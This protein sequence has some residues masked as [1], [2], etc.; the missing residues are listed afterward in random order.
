MNK[1]KEYLQKKKGFW[2]ALLLV[3]LV[4]L[5]CLVVALRAGKLQN[6]FNPDSFAQREEQDEEFDPEGYGLQEDGRDQGEDD[7]TEENSFEQGENQEKKIQNL[8]LNEQSGEQQTDR[9]EEGNEQRILYVDQKVGEGMERQTKTG[10]NENAGTPEKTGED[11]RKETPGGQQEESDQPDHAAPQPGG[12]EP[13]N[14]PGDSGEEGGS[15]SSSDGDGEN[16]GSSHPDGGEEGGAWVAE[17]LTVTYYRNQDAVSLYKEQVPSES[18]VRGNI[19]VTS[20]WVEKGNPSNKKTEEETDFTLEAIPE[21]YAHRLTDADVN[22]SFSLTVTCQGLTGTVTCVIKNDYIRYTGMHVSYNSSP[23]YVTGETLFQGQEINDASI[24]NAIT[25]DVYGRTVQG[26]QEVYLPDEKNYQ[27]E[28]PEETGGVA[29]KKEDGSQWTADI[30]YCGPG[31]GSSV[32]LRGTD[33]VRYSVRDYRL[34]VMYDENTVLDTIYTD[35]KTVVLNGTYDGRCPYNEMV[36]RLQKNGK[37]MTNADGYLTDLFYGWSSRYPAVVDNREISYTF[38]EGQHTQIMYA[39]PLAPLLSEGYLVKT[40]GDDQVLTGYVPDKK[41]ERLDVPYGITRVDLGEDFQ[42][43]EEAGG[44]KVLALSATVN[45]VNLSAAGKKFPMLKEYSLFPLGQSSVDNSEKN[46]IFS[47]EDGLLYSRDQS[48]LWKVPADCQSFDIEETVETIAEGALS[49]AAEGTKDNETLEITMHGQNPP[50][51]VRSETA[52]VFGGSGCQVQVEVPETE[53]GVVKDLIYKR[54]LSSWGAVFDEELGAAGAASACISTKDHASDRYENNGGDVYAVSGGSRSLAF[55]TRDSG[56]IYNVPEDVEGIEPY[57]FAEP[58]EVQFVNVGENIGRLESCSFAT[59]EGESL[60]GVQISGDEPIEIDRYVAGEQAPRGI[61]FYISLAQN[62]TSGWVRR[63]TEDYGAE[64]A[65]SMLT[66]AEGSLFIDGQGCAYL[67]QDDHA[68]T[69]CSVPEDLEEYEIPSGYTLNNVADGAFAWCQNLIYL[70]LPDVTRVG[71]HAF[72]NCTGLEILVLSHPDLEEIPEAFAGCDALETVV[73]GNEDLTPELP[74][75]TE[76]LAGSRYF[77]RDRMVCETKDDGGCAV[78]NVP[79]DTAG[80]VSLPEN[81]TEIGRKAF[82]GCKT[83][84]GIAAAQMNQ[85]RKIGAYAFSGCTGLEEVLIGKACTSLGEKAFF[86]CDALKTVTWLGDTSVVGDGVFAEN[87]RLEAVYFGDNSGQSIATIGAYTFENCRSLQMV[88]FQ[89]GVRKIGDSCFRG[90]S[91]M[92]T[93]ITREYAAFCE[94]IGAYAF[95]DCSRYSQTLSF[96]SG[97]QEIGRGAFMNC[98]YLSSMWIPS[99]LREIPEDCFAGCRSM[100][101]V[102]FMAGA[103]LRSVGSHAFSG[104]V[105]LETLT[106]L[107]LLT[108]LTSLGEGVFSSEEVDG[109]TYAACT[110]LTC[111]DLPS[112]IQQI[113]RRAFA[114]CT[115]LEELEV[116]RAEALTSLGSGAFTGCTSLKSAVLSG[117]GIQVLPENA[118]DGCRSLEALLLPES[119]VSIEARAVADCDSLSDM[120]IC[121]RDKVVSVDASALVGTK[122]N[123]RLAIYVPYTENHGLRNAYRLSLGWWTALLN[124]FTGESPITIIQDREMGEETFVENGGLYARKA[125]GSFRLLQVI[126]MTD[127]SFAVK[128]N[129]TE[130]DE[131]ALRTCEDLAILELPAS[132][133]EFPEGT[134]E[135]CSGLEVLLIPGNLRMELPASLFGEGRRISSFALWVSEGDKAYY[136]EQGNF[137]VRSYGQMG[138]VQ[139]GVLYGVHVSDGTERILLDYVPKSFAGELNIFLGTSEVADGAAEGC[140]SLTVVNSAYTVERIG[141]HAFADCT[142]L[143]TVDLTSF[144]TTALTEIGDYAFAGCRSLVGENTGEGK[145]DQMLIPSTVQSYGTGMLKDCTSLT[146]LS[147]QGRAAELPDEFCSGCRNLES[148]SLA[149]TLL[150]S[151]TRIGKKAFYQCEKITSISWSNMPNLETVDDSAYEGC[152]SLVQATFA[153]KIKAFGRAVF[154]DTALEMLSFNGVNPPKLGE[155]ILSQEEQNRV[156]VYIPAGDDGEIYLRYYEAWKDTYPT[157]VSRMISQDGNEYRAVNNILYLIHPGQEKEMTAIK[158]PTSVS[159]AQ[160]YNSSTLYCTGLGDGSF[161]DCRNLASLVIPNRVETIG[162]GV[163]ENCTRLAS[164]FIEGDVLQ[165]I[166]E[167]AFKNCTS[168]TTLELPQTV[169][170]LGS[171]MLEG[172]SSFETLT[173]HGYSPFALGETIFGKT[174]DDGVRIRVPLASY[175]DYLGQWGAQLDEEYGEGAGKR[176]LMAVSEDGTEK[177]E[178][179]IRYLRVNGHWEEAENITADD[180]QKDGENGTDRMKGDIPEENVPD[181]EE[182]KKDT[183]EENTSGEET[184]AEDG[185]GEDTAKESTPDE[186]TPAEDEAGEDTAEENTP[187]GETPA[188]DESVEDTAEESTPEGEAPAENETEGDTAK[189]SAPEGKTPASDNAGNGRT[190]TSHTGESTGKIYNQDREGQRQ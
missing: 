52:P 60:Q 156:N 15:D 78:R 171:G 21:E 142:S 39:I 119:L 77:A 109:Q 22:K 58:G 180:K 167:E 12:Q 162:R 43:S 140:E 23:M 72:D 98:T 106:N 163:F 114:G 122:N 86:G 34:T 112:S 50:E 102:V 64:M 57:A 149:R 41:T 138:E 44:V 174:V 94:S 81:V 65:E 83:I 31:E 70:E 124:I 91:G 176:I 79:T 101:S 53:T 158:V 150:N 47:T 152:S 51:L 30:L 179:G 37:Y 90:C 54:Y 161:K 118:F 89:A 26:G 4:L 95:A 45:S 166:G 148:V 100:R 17:E 2:P 9:K 157:L 190:E 127:R 84:T 168:L 120:S 131:D 172:C 184:P 117:T 63:F 186:E 177:I 145:S 115:A 59:L 133:R 48:I 5:L 146:S 175:Q 97:L 169:R 49:D 139:G 14:T 144:S 170:S 111:A 33:A 66:L 67:E 151:V 93:S 110:A 76:L 19:T 132:L 182:T 82:A 185:S 62:Q 74:R 128:E 13:G 107:E 126:T 130:I 69:L 99:Q 173:V 42:I 159:S 8:D 183:A 61:R 147:L 29:A 7:S 46:H 73:L 160:I 165:S 96:F 134:L 56:N 71:K 36:E 153:G 24:R 35:D 28:F 188:E 129:T 108:E 27:I 155:N 75:Q 189:E 113:G 103:D 40:K 6:M 10:D 123:G 154:R 137:P 87:S 85:I 178:N 141:A 104:C 20:H 164:I 16:N 18:Y 80:S 181:P 32:V 92:R 121:R 1:I 187:E 136:E 55:I 11:S 88:Y 3:L 143:K 125:D 116:G 38:R 135:N 105:S 68:L 25:L